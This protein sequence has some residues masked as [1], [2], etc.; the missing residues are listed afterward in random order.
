MTATYQENGKYKL[1]DDEDRVILRV[2][3]TP[4]YLTSDLAYHAHKYERGFDLMV[5]VFGADHAGHVPRIQS[6]MALLGYDTSKLAFSLV[7]MV[8]IVRGGEEVKVSKRR[9]SVFELADLV[10]EAGADACRFSFLMKAADAQ[11]DFDL[12]LVARQSRENPVFYF[13]YGHAR[14]AGILR[15]AREKGLEL[16]PEALTDAELAQLSLPEEKALLKRMSQLPD[17]VAQAAERLEPHLVL[18]FCQDLIQDFHSYY[19][20]YKKTDPILGD[21]VQKSMGRLALVAAL[22]LTLQNAFA[23]LGIDAPE[24]MQAPEEES[25]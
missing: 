11:L 21:D 9:G 13:Q 24:H 20:R 7:Q 3:G 6:G 10:E 19:S 22:K 1:K 25:P 23:V 4:V 15:K 16:A 18:Y 14:C 5:D 8:R 12:D 17:V 2:D